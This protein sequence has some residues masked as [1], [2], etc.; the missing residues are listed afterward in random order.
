MNKTASNKKYAFDQEVD[1]FID[2]TK[3]IYRHN[4]GRKKGKRHIY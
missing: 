1:V 4:I 3:V 2:A